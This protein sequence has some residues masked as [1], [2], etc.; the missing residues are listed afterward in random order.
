VDSAPDI[1]STLH[2]DGVDEQDHDPEGIADHE[3]CELEA[4]AG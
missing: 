4:V 2:G 3:P 1:V